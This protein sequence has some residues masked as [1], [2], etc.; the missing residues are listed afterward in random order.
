[1]Q[2]CV[3]QFFEKLGVDIKDLSWNLI[4][5]LNQTFKQATPAGFWL[6]SKAFSK[7]SLRTFAWDSASVSA[8]GMFENLVALIVRF[9]SAQGNAPIAAEAVARAARDRS[10]P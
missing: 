4:N 3:R 2:L 10:A 9:R 6:R 8:F 1:M 5:G 7:S